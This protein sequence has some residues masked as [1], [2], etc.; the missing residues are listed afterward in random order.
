MQLRILALLIPLLLNALP[1]V[2]ADS[3]P[4]P[5]P[6]GFPKRVQLHENIEKNFQMHAELSPEV[7]L[8]AVDAYYPR[9]EEADAKRRIASARRLEVQGVFDPTISTLDGY[10]WMQN[11]SKFVT[12][13]K[14]VFNQP[15]LEIPFRSGVKLFGTYRFNPRSAQSPYI[16]TGFIG[17]FGGGITV[18]LMRGLFINERNIA[19]KVA[20][21]GEPLATQTFSLTRLDILLRASLSYWNWVG[22]QRKMQVA[23]RLVQLSSILVQAADK[24]AAAGDLARIEV[25]EAEEDVQRRKADQIA[26]E[27]DFKKAT[28]DLALFLFDSSGRPCPFLDEFNV[29]SHWPAPRGFSGDELDKSVLKAVGRRPELKSIA[30]ERQ[31]ATLQLKLAR[32]DLLPQADATYTQGYDSGNSGIGNVFRAQVVVSQPLYLRNARGKIKA[33]EFNIEALNAAQAAE[34]QRIV[35]EVM[36]AGAAINAAYEKFLALT[37]QTEKAEQVYLGEQKRFDF[38]DST[39]FLVTQRERQLFDARIKLV[40]AQ[41]EFLQAVARMQALSVEY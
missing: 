21:I 35:C 32:N 7:F 26:S 10:T 29:P 14:V 1:V 9:L 4:S 30:L 39:V 33:A 24:R 2:A 16:E 25:T 28:Y 31:Q 17:E 40:D 27:L 12:L 23:R 41:V 3:S 19:E 20:K 15:M 37:T 8:K 38:G 6:L 36:T 13:K 22:A 11:T 18:P 34:R 5:E